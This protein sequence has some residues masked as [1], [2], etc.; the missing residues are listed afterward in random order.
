MAVTIVEMFRTGHGGGYAPVVDAT[1]VLASQSITAGGAASAAFN[2]RTSLVE[3]S[4]D[5]GAYV[6]F[7]PAPSGSGPAFFVPAGGVRH[8]GVQPGWKAIAVS[9]A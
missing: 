1:A 7:G 6:E 9:A 2:A 4:S 3:V 8:I 5:D